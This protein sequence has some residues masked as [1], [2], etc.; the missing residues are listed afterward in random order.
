MEKGGVLCPYE[1]QKAEGTGVTATA[2]SVLGGSLSSHPFAFYQTTFSNT[3]RPR[4]GCSTA[5]RGGCCGSTGP[6]GGSALHTAGPPIT[7]ALVPR[8]LWLV[9][10]LPRGREAAVEK[11]LIFQPTSNGDRCHNRDALSPLVPRQPS[12]L[13]GVLSATT[14]S[15][16]QRALGTE[17]PRPLRDTG[18]LWA[19][20]GVALAFRT[21]FGLSQQ[22]EALPCHVL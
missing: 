22:M 1:P 20:R 3:K 13:L 17:T 5:G 16:A 4:W 14:P 9:M 10:G 15:A 21:P 12:C 19:W 7:G 2:V 6:C 8:T 11:K 18:I